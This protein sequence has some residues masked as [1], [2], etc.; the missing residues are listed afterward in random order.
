MQRPSSPEK[1]GERQCGQYGYRPSGG[2]KPLIIDFS[3]SAERLTYGDAIMVR[4]RGQ[5]AQL[6]D[7]S[8]ITLF[9]LD[10][11][12]SGTVRIA[13]RG[14][15]VL[16]IFAAAVVSALCM[17]SAH[18]AKNNYDIV[19]SDP[20]TVERYGLDRSRFGDFVAL[21]GSGQPLW[22]CLPQGGGLHRRRG[23]RP[24][25]GSRARGRG[26]QPL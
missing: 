25:S 8:A 19:T 17:G 26:G 5:G 14:G 11:G 7:Y 22:T 23:S 18:V 16:D 6:A 10:P 3:G 9:N 13:E 20:G 24:P 4:A 12:L 2:S 1:P 21:T 15:G